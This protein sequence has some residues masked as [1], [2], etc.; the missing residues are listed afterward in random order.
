LGRDDGGR[1]FF[2]NHSVDWRT[3]CRCTGSERTVVHFL[4]LCLQDTLELDFNC[5]RVVGLGPL[6]Y[7]AQRG[8]SLRPIYAV[9]PQRGPLV[10]LDAWMPLC[11]CKCKAQITN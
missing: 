10:I 1:R 8:V 9:T 11:R 5:Q 2:D 3:F 6:S 7:E 4:V